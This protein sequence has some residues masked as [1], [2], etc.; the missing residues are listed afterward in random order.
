[1][2]RVRAAAEGTVRAMSS[3]VAWE[4]ATMRVAVSSAR[5]MPLP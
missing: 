5:R 4:M 1:M 3:A 2:T